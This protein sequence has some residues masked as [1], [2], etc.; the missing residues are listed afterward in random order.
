MLNLLRFRAQAAYTPDANAKPCSGREAYARYSR[1][2]LEQLKAIGGER[3][4]MG[5]ALDAFIAPP[6]E[7]WDKV[8][9]VRYPSISTFLRM[10]AQPDYRAAALEDARLIVTRTPD[11]D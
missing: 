9:L 4:W 3:V 1:M 8:L 5:A 7:R 10:L 6:G 2:V 11:A